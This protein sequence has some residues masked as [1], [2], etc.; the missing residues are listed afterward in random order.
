MSNSSSGHAP[1]VLAVT[2]AMLDGNS[3]SSSKRTSSRI[4]KGGQQ[5]SS[6]PQRSSTRQ[7][8]SQQ[9]SDGTA[10]EESPAVVHNGGG[11]RSASPA[12][13]RARKQRANKEASEENEGGGGAFSAA[14]ASLVASAPP[15]ATTGEAQ[16]TPTKSD[17]AARP[18]H[19]RGKSQ[20]QVQAS[21]RFN[22]ADEAIPMEEQPALRYPAGRG[23]KRTGGAIPSQHQQHTS[24]PL[25]SN[26]RSESP[27][28]GMLSKSAPASSFLEPPQAQRRTRKQSQK[29]SSNVAGAMLSSADE[30]DMPGSATGH[31]SLTWQ[32]QGLSRKASGG[33][34]ANGSSKYAKKPVPALA[35]TKDTPA[36]GI[37]A[38]A[39]AAAEPSPPPSSMTWQ[40]QLFRQAPAPAADLFSALEDGHSGAHPAKDGRS[41]TSPAKPRAL[42]RSQ[43]AQEH[44]YKLDTEAIDRS[45]SGLDLEERKKTRG[46]KNK[47]K[48]GTASPAKSISIPC[49]ALS[50]QGKKQHS[51][52]PR[53][54]G[55]TSE[56]DTSVD[57]IADLSLDET[58]TASK[59]I[60]MS[61]SP[62]KS[63]LYAGP[64]FHNSPSAGQLP[65]PRLRAFLSRT[66]GDQSPAEVLAS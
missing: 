57:E 62:S 32:Q 45:F 1:G 29:G 25:S 19:R 50:S 12:K 56:S 65:T 2:S 22:D 27:T 66:K 46:K 10:G 42:Q 9:L 5:R 63:T 43:S 3:G 41:R 53:G 14:L 40:Q 49:S 47:K 64:K 61:A 52:R 24:H 8:H 59:P 13:P 16:D 26:E 23:S 55:L 15:Q 31:D 4:S 35:T 20:N 39:S 48:D 51:T 44:E 17:S 36:S 30:W 60:S 37:S 34:G 11:S 7:S 28:P 6:T 58:P 54:V 18:K 21:A 33:G 38:L